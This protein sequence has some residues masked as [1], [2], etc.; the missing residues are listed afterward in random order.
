GLS[1][2]FNI[3]GG[4]G[5]LLQANNITDS[6]GIATTAF[7]AGTTSGEVVINVSCDGIWNKTTITLLPSS[8][9]DIKIFPEG[10]INL[11]VNDAQQ[12]T[13]VAYD[14]YGNINTFWQPYWR[15]EGNIGIINETG[16]FTAVKKGT[17]AVNCTDNATG[18]YNVSIV[19]VNNSK[20][21]I[22]SWSPTE[23]SQTINET[24]NI[25]FTVNAS[26][27]DDDIL[28]INWYLNDSL[29]ATCDSYTFVANYTSA[30]W[31]EV[32]VI[33]SDGNLSAN[34]TWILTV[35]NINRHPTIETIG[36]KIAYE[37]QVFN[38]Q[39]NATDPD[40]DD[41]TF[42][43]NTALFDIN[44]TTGLISFTPNYDSAGVYFINV[45]VTDGTDIV[46]QIF[47]LTVI[48]VNRAPTA[49]IS[50][51][52]NNSKHAT[53]D[54]I[55]FD[56]T[57]SYDPDNDILTYTWSS[58]IDGIIGYTKSFSAKLSAGTHTITLTV[59]DGSLSDT[60]QIT[61]TV[62][63][64]PE[65]PWWFISADGLVIIGVICAV[66]LVIVVLRKLK[67]V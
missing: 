65:R 44:P 6:N 2:N 30:G 32:K 21:V 4:S 51:P 17:G 15:L 16:F 42:S 10:P 29:V 48:N 3:E 40:D 12:F 47:K 20:P 39:I 41:I 23:K 7:I 57:D 18:I 37:G 64:P 46:W 66:I 25:T 53:S 1:V 36:D 62:E 49:V 8:I 19:I 43:D 35:T 11:Y 33:V 45:T 14:Q 27:P 31:Y 59:T 52:L 22:E 24:E 63:K 9:T 56:A 50:S 38:L 26:D 28:T 58:N 60:K 54:S 67:G 13:A 5:T 34:Y 55:S 61:I